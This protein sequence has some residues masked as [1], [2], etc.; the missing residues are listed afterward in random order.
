[1]TIALQ[2][3]S[4]ENP[5]AGLRQERPAVPQRFR[6]PFSCGRWFIGMPANYPQT[7]MEIHTIADLQM[8]SVVYIIR[9]PV[10][11]PEFI[12]DIRALREEE[13]ATEAPITP[14][15][16]SKAVDVLDY[17]ATVLSADLPRALIAP[18]GDG[19]I[20]IEWLRGN[21]NVRVLIPPRSEQPAFIYRRTGRDSDVHA[22]S[23]AAVVQ[24]LR[25]VILA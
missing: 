4:L 12:S 15:A 24:T 3:L 17:V 25:S 23:R 6:I 7:P 13:R 1:M 5:I 10:N 8:G 2:N 21:L 9:T 14:Y 18:D 20:R 16:Y 19:G 22:F 11:E